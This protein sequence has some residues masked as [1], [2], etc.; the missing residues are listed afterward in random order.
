MKSWRPG[1]AVTQAGQSVFIV[2]RR[3]KTT[4]TEDGS[5]VKEEVDCLAGACDLVKKQIINTQYVNIQFSKKPVRLK[6]RK[7]GKSELLNK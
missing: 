4:R 7:L 1:C 2:L 5:K 6:D 3:S